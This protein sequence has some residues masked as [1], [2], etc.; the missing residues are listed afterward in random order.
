M[1]TKCLKNLLNNAVTELIERKH[2][3]TEIQRKDIT[4]IDRIKY[5]G[6]EIF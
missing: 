4:F 6:H 5:A 3:L 2:E 1:K